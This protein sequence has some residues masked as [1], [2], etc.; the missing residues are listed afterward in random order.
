MS[1]TALGLL[2]ILVECENGPCST[3]GHGHC[4]DHPCGE[5]EGGCLVARARALL[6]GQQTEELP[7]LIVT[8]E[9]AIARATAIVNGRWSCNNT[10]MA[11]EAD[12][13]HRSQTLVHIAQAD[14]ADAAALVALASVLPT[15]AEMRMRELG[16]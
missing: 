16:F 15:E 10:M 7:Q 12:T 9:D 6:A 1:D 11:V 14:A 8:R 13:E 5:D 2:R 4:Q 3:D